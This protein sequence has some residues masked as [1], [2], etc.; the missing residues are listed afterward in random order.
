MAPRAFANDPAALTRFVRIMLRILIGTTVLSLFSDAMQMQLLASGEFS[1]VEAEANDARQRIVAMAHLFVYIVTA[2]AFLRWI[3]RAN[4]NVRALGAQGLRFTPGWAVGWYFVPFLNLVR[5]YAVM[6]EIWQ[7]SKDPDAWAAQPIPP[8]LRWW[9]GLFLIAGF[10]GQ[11]SL[12]LTLQANT[13][14]SLTTATVV[15]MLSEV[16]EIALCVLALTLVNGVSEM[17][18]QVA[19]SGV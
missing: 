15:S 7:A 10:L 14:P 4:A 3:H 2:V 19:R 11:A 16:V 17:Q 18:Q 5:P 1:A 9:W 8:L 6:K 12:R 13:V